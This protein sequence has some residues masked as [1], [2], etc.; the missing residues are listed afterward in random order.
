MYEPGRILTFQGH[1]EFD[2]F[3]NSETIKTFFARKAP[4]W[5]ENSLK[6]VDADDD[7]EVAAEMVLQFVMQKTRA[8]QSKTHALISG[9]ATPPEEE[10]G[11]P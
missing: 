4:E 9:L 8:E 1:F 11:N 3:I 2:R 7:A 6:A 10:V 5:L